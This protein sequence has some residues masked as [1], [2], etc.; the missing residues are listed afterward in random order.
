[1]AA[2]F[3]PAYLCDLAGRDFK[4]RSTEPTPTWLG[5]VL[6]DLSDFVEHVGVDPTSVRA[7]RGLLWPDT[8]YGHARAFAHV[9]GLLVRSGQC[10]IAPEGF[11]RGNHL[12]LVRRPE[13]LFIPETPLRELLFAKHHLLPEHDSVT[14]ALTLDNVLVEDQEDGWVVDEKWWRESQ[15]VKDRLHPYS[16]SSP[17]PHA[18]RSSASIDAIVSS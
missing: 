7:A 11:R 4:F 12:Q 3:V 1:M 17:P 16:S 6:R 8:E 13:G 10:L 9:L 5:D 18:L 14:K 15:Q 2:K